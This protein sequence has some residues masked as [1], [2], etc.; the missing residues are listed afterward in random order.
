MRYVRVEPT[1]TLLEDDSAFPPVAD[2]PAAA[3]RVFPKPAETG[4]RITAPP[5]GTRHR[6]PQRWLLALLGLLLV[7]TGGWLGYGE[8]RTSAVQARY[9]A[10][11]DGR[12]GYRVESGAAS[13]ESLPDPGVGP[14]DERL[15]YNRLP[16]TIAGLTSRGYIV[17]AQARVTPEFRGLAD[18][19]L[20]PIYREK[21]QAGLLILDDGGRIAYSAR[22]PERVFD[23]F[24]AIPSQVV[25]SLLFIENRELLHPLAATSNPAVEWDRLAKVTLDLALGA[26]LDD[27]HKPAGASTLATQLEK[28]RHSPGG[29]TG[30]AT[31]KLRQMASASLRAYLDGEQTLDA[32]RRIVLSYINT[33][34]LS[35]RAG[36]GE[37]NGLGD[38]LWAWY[39]SSLEQLRSAL[40]VKP[41]AGTDAAHEQARLYKQ[42]LSLFIAQRRPSYYLSNPESLDALTNVYLNLLASAGVIDPRLRD[43]AQRIPLKL[44]GSAS[45][46]V[47]SGVNKATNAV[48]GR[49]ADMLGVARRYDLDRVDMTV[50][51][52]VDL[53]M[54]QAV[55]TVLRTLAD[56]KHARAAGLYGRRLLGPDDDLTSIV[57]S[58]TLLERSPDG[59]AVRVQTDN[60]DQ[61]FDINEGVKLELGSTAKLRT[62]VSYLNIIAEL[63]QR[64]AGLSRE[65]R[66]A[67][68]VPSRNVLALWAVRWLNGAQ[69]TSLTTMLEAA[70]ERRYSASPGAGFYTGGAMHTFSNFNK[71]DDGRVISVREALQSSVNLVFV[72]MMRDIERYYVWRSEDSA[73]ALLADGDASLRAAYLTRF[74]DREGSTFLQRFYRKYLA[75]SP[76]DALDSLLSGIRMSPRKLAVIYSSI[77]PSPSANG[78]GALF[79]HYLPATTL[80]S[81]DTEALFEKYTP[82]R[83]SLADR[84]YITRVHPLELWV[85]GY[86]RDHPQAKIGEVLAASV[87]E[88]Q[89]V[90]RWLFRTR[91][92]SAQNRRI[93][94]LLEVEAFA[95]ILQDWKRVGYPFDSLVPSYATALGSSADRP[96]ALAELMGIIVNDGVR[97]PTVRIDKVHLAEGTPYETVVGHAAPIG[98]QVLAPEVARVVRNALMGVVAR[99]TARRL[100]TPFVRG[101]G[102]AIPVGG[103]TGTG[104]NRF[105]V[106][107]HN[108]VLIRSGVMSRT[109]TFVFFIGG[110]FYGTLTAYVPGHAAGRY[111]FTSALP[112]QILKTLAPTL[113]PIVGAAEGAPVHS[114][115]KRLP[116][117]GEAPDEA[118]PPMPPDDLT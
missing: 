89:E 39:G 63:H 84:G 55:T 116:K 53:P 20:F 13:P 3:V 107:G 28:Y 22:Y 60:Y 14:Y 15:G 31:E 74:A 81:K 42:A 94:Y 65:A 52:T 62:L 82:Q 86:L 71:E 6:H 12:L 25:A 44:T 64:Y 18:W 51:S 30:S 46:Q 108:G 98:E 112:V 29:V 10:Q 85:M 35:A 36:Y 76:A 26:V 58:F 90:Y 106:F 34:P 93:R 2:A 57:Y 4:G 59:N 97:Y 49:L 113:A 69:D 16:A 110:H 111:K 95:E 9:L 61:P 54:Q 104:D 32:R 45:T 21:D 48:R 115:P 11:L 66:T 1:I 79:K 117:G 77:E 23:S 91:R 50:S 102:V 75:K 68:K 17:Q 83:Y 40:G 19:G 88:R 38:G 56:S 67:M 96:A 24:A 33:V 80:T 114:A 78:L 100:G 105:D 92:K 72:R 103:K 7:A 73:A 101:D 99:G 118:L 43:A 109:A 41:V 70:M 87:E 37:I 5:P 47:N 8:L 27:D